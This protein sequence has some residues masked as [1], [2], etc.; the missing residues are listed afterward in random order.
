MPTLVVSIT[1]AKD[2][3]DKA[4]IGFVVANASAASGVETIVFLS[5]EGVHLSQQ[6]YSDD[7]HE[8]GFKPLNE[9]IASYTANGGQVWV[10]SP[11]FVRRGLSQ[12][13]LVEN[14]LITGAAKLVEALVSGASCVSY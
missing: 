9:L 12:E 4:T 7:I 11:C 10:C 3:R 6:G 2:N 1:H 14:A 5:S 8:E 13:Q